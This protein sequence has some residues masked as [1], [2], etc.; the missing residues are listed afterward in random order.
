MGVRNYAERSDDALEPDSHFRHKHADIILL[1][2]VLFKFNKEV[3]KNGKYDLY[4]ADYRI[5]A[6]TIN[7]QCGSRK[8]R[9]L[10]E[11]LCYQKIE[12][13]SLDTRVRQFYQYE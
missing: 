7:K 10:K 3:D 9:M 6:E 2:E 8:L 11:I 12:N 4:A 5:L 1:G 13:R